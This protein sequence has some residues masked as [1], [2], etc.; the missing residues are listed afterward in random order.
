MR[1]DTIYA[2][3]FRSL[4]FDYVRMSSPGYTADPWDATPSGLDYPFVRVHLD[5]RI[6]TIVGGNESGKSQM[7]AAVTAALTGDGYDRSD[8]CRYSPFFSVDKTLV[9]PEFGAE[10]KDVSVQDVEFLEK[11]CGAKDLVGS[12]RVAIFRVNTTPLLR[13]YARKSGKWSEPF[14][15]K[16]PSLLKDLGI[17]RPFTIDAEVPLPDSVPLEFLATGKPVAGV[18]RHLLRGVWDL[19]TTNASW[20]ETNESVSK[21]A[22]P[23]SQ[24]F[25]VTQTVDDGELAKFRLAADLLIKITGLEQSLFVEL[26]KAVRTKNGY[27]NSIVDSIN[28]ELAKA[29]NFPHWW[30]QDSHFE[31]FVSLFEYVLGIHDSRP[32]RA[33]LWIRRA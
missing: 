28:A 6:T 13:M 1:L 2:R 31:L 32:H 21:Q 17:P 26:Q 15:V 16:I 10:F 7:L 22:G 12:D 11:M 29:L 14:H 19:F 20:F 3:F 25:G 27:A 23:I 24:A 18:G 4:N 33:F 5:D 30:S 9:K 8:F